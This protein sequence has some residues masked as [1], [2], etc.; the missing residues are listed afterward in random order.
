[1]II[2]FTVMA[3]YLRSIIIIFLIIWNLIIIDL[4]FPNKTMF[5]PKQNGDCQQ[6]LAA[7][8]RAVLSNVVYCLI[9][10]KSQ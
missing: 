10:Q 4:F 8:N 7:M 1:M 5:Q 2:T 9:K 6:K 3:C